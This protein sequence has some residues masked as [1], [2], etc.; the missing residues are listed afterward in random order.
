MGAGHAVQH[1]LSTELL[2]ES[3]IR[4]RIPD[5]DLVTVGETVVDAGRYRPLPV[6]VWHGAKPVV[7][8]QGV[9]IRERGK[10]RDAKQLLAE[11]TDSG[12]IY[13]I[14][15]PVVGELLPLPGVGVGSQ[16]IVDPDLSSLAIHEAPE[17]A[18][19]HGCAGNLEAPR[20][21]RDVSQTFV[22]KEPK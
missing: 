3:K 17:V 10:R 8:D 18:V 5:V 11:R 22:G 1:G 4:L 12:R 21:G 9:Y 2:K 6:G 7:L 15:L 16:R 13:D 14:Q 20:K 19:P